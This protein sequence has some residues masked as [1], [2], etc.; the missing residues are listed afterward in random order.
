MPANDVV[1]DEESWRRQ[2]AAYVESPLHRHLGLVLRVEGPGEVIVR[3]TPPPWTA[4][5]NGTIAGG[6]LTTMIDSAVCQAARTLA[7]PH[8]R[9]WTLAMNVDFIHPARLG[10]DLV[11]R[12]RIESMRRTIAVGTG[13]ALGPDGDLL[14]V[15]LVTATLRPPT[16]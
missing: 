13:R 10:S 14:A 16:V 4:N 11:V 8:L 6:I 9:V 5:R 12:G 2:E 7:E 15:G 3:L 1:P